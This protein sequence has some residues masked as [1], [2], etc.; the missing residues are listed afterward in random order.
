MDL[1]WV[2][3]TEYCLAVLLTVAL[4][5]V[6][7]ILIWKIAWCCRKYRLRRKIEMKYL[8]LE[9]HNPNVSIEFPSQNSYYRILAECQS[10]DCDYPESSKNIVKGQKKK[11]NIPELSPNFQTTPFIMNK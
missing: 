1:F 4:I 8:V 10:S 9:D 7:I 11:G 2:K 6:F 5:V 3:T